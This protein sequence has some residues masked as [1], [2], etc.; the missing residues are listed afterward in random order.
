M[1]GCGLRGRPPDRGTAPEQVHPGPLSWLKRAPR[2][3]FRER[4]LPWTFT[5]SGV[6][7]KQSF[8]GVGGQ[9]HLG[10][11]PTGISPSLALAPVPLFQDPGGGRAQGTLRGTLPT[12]QAGARLRRRFF[13]SP[14]FLSLPTTGHRAPRWALLSAPGPRVVGRRVASEARGRSSRLGEGGARWGAQILTWRT[15][16]RTPPQHAPRRRM[17]RTKFLVSSGA[18]SP[19]HSPRRGSNSGGGAGPALP[20]WGRGEGKGREGRGKGRKEEER[21]GEGV[22]R[23]GRRGKGGEEEEGGGKEGEGR[24]KGERGERRKGEGGAPWGAQEAKEKCHF[25]LPWLLPCFVVKEMSSPRPAQ[26]LESALELSCEFEPHN[27]CRD[28]S[29]LRGETK[30]GRIG[31][32][33][34]PT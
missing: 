19:A 8:K 16:S 22:R 15:A 24:R 13:P 21:R 9:I 32:G 27:G 12:T 30:A 7:N 17:G 5:A 18:P 25:L 20:E 4:I 3:K 11:V 1:G 14:S 29:N 33:G 2:E 31:R 6:I 23:G 28:D 26:S 34:T 10:K